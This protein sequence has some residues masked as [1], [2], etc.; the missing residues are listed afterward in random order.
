[1]VKRIKHIRYIPISSKHLEIHHQTHPAAWG[2]SSTIIHFTLYRLE[3]TLLCGLFTECCLILLLFSSYQ[4]SGC[5]KKPDSCLCEEK[6]KNK[7]QESPWSPTLFSL[8]LH[9]SLLFY[10]FPLQHSFC[11]IHNIPLKFQPHAFRNQTLSQE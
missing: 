1:M 8:L 3:K 5:K 4:L 9:T 2:V 10:L 6:N 11:A 7:Q